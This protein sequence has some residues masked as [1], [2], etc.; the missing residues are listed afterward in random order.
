MIKNYV[1]DAC[2]LVAYISDEIGVDEVHKILESAK[3][4]K[5]R[6]FMH[7]VNLLEVYYGI[8]REY[9]EYDAEKLLESV[10]EEQVTICYDMNRKMLSEAGKLK[11][12]YKLSLA[13]SIGLAQ[14][15]LLNASFVSSDHHELDIVDVSENINIFWFR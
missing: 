1:L 14:A 11:A 9:G 6:V 13:D 4:G 5:C 3:Q 2:A 12:S 8:R 10:E 7:A 15:I